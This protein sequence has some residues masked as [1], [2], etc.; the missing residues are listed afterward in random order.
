[1]DNELVTG[2]ASHAATGGGKSRQPVVSRYGEIFEEQ[3]GYYMSMGMSYHDYWDGDS[4]M[5]K[6]YRDMY[7]VER[8]RQNELLWL[9]GM[10]FYEALCDASPIL[11]SASRKRKPLPYR[12][13]PIPLTKSANKKMK[14]R[15]NKQR[16]NNGIEVMRQKMAS[17]NK[18]FS[19]KEG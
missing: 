18:K 14:D 3:C 6:Y 11:N 10:Y 7:E 2:S 17:I 5:T 12:K 4:T 8:D 13:Q 9:Q 16:M 1:M 19:G 15:E